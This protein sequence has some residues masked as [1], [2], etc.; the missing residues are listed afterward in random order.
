MT[1]SNQETTLAS[2][3]ASL[4]IESLKT[5]VAADRCVYVMVHSL[6]VILIFDSHEMLLFGFCI[7]YPV[8]LTI[9]IYLFILLSEKDGR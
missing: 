1:K 3:E 6:D 5:Q 9:Y 7:H 4:V 2:K 8:H